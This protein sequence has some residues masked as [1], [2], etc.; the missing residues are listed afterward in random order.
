MRW[1]L[2]VIVMAI[3]TF[4]SFI[5]IIFLIKTKLGIVYRNNPPGIDCETI[6]ENYEYD[7]LKQFAYKEALKTDKDVFELTLN[8]ITSR[9]G[10]TNCFCK[11]EENLGSATD[12]EYFV[13]VSTNCDTE[14]KNCAV[15]Q[16]SYPIC[17]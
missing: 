13:T 7:N 12:K 14:G 1:T 16:A 2:V 9:S 11:E 10:T 3:F 5:F 17:K 6:L 15:E 8:E 4:G